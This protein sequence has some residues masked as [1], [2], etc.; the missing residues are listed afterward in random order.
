MR[1]NKIILG[2]LSALILISCAISKKKT[3][4]Y[5]PCYFE[6][7]LSFYDPLSSEW[8]DTNYTYHF[9]I[10]KSENIKIVHES[11][12]KIGYQRLIDN[13][14]F[15]DWSSKKMPLIERIDSLI[16]TFQLDTI[17]SKY[18][19]EFW[20]RRIKERNEDTVYEVLREIQSILR[21]EFV[22]LNDKFVNDTLVN[23]IEIDIS[24]DSLTNEI[25]MKNFVYL[26]SVGFHQS[27]YNLLYERYRYYEIDWDRKLLESS[28]SIDTNC[29]CVT[30][31]I[32]DN[33]K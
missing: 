7:K 4:E 19:Y 21:K 28:L 13:F 29:L 10:R 8:W 6:N 33:T 20:D 24:E 32:Q 3:L 2:L 22:T 17:N 9:W 25:A 16:I 27:A 31:W 26:K 30:P 18:Y 12:K 11:F 14:Y 15:A 5:L 1:R 23:L